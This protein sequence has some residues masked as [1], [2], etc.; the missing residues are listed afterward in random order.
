METVTKLSGA[1][2]SPD[3]I[4]RALYLI[5]RFKSVNSVSALELYHAGDDM[6][7]EADVVLPLTL[8]LKEA[9]DLGEIVTYC[10][11]SIGQ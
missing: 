3:A 7:V 9:H 5:T 1:A 2:A 10:L 4:T 11:E 8:A 6:I